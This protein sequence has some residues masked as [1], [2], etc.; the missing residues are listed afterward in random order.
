MKAAPKHASFSSLSHPEVTIT[1]LFEENNPGS[2]SM[3]VSSGIKEE[4][5]GGDANSY[6]AAAAA[7]ASP[8]RQPRQLQLQRMETD[9]HHSAPINLTSNGNHGEEE[10]VAMNLSNKPSPA[11]QQPAR[12]LLSGS[13]GGIALCAKMRLKKQRLLAAAE[14]QQ[15]QQQLQQQQQHHD[16]VKKSKVSEMTHLDHDPH[17]ALHRLAEAAER[18]QVKKPFFL[19][20]NF[21]FPFCTSLLDLSQE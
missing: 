21:F 3:T 1:R 18:K 8:P 13:T 20:G 19:S 10:E 14:Q 5:V 17:S 16:A 7:S 2:R 9:D 11:P 4:E 15:Q 12:S 6:M